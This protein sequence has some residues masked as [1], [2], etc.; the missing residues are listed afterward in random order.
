MFSTNGFRKSERGLEQPHEKD[1]QTTQSSFDNGP[2][3][4]GAANCT[5]ER[6][7]LPRGRFPTALLFLEVPP[8]EV[9]VNVHPAK[10]SI[11]C[12]SS[13]VAWQRRRS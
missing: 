12:W 11:G 8:G 5:I 10:L 1:T 6:D 13:A 7:L 2:K 9:D 3:A 4:S